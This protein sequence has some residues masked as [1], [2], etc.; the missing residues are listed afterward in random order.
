MPHCVDRTHTSPDDSSWKLA[1]YVIPM[2]PAESKSVCTRNR[3]STESWMEWLP[4]RNFRIIWPWIDL[5]VEWFELVLS[6]TH[7]CNP[8]FS[9]KKWNQRQ[10][11]KVRIGEVN[12]ETCK[13]ISSWG[14][15]G[16]TLKQRM[17]NK[18]Y[19]NLHELVL[20]FH[21]LDYDWSNANLG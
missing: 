18:F 10:N 5:D 8:K 14:K 20:A 11:S 15:V 1:I 21:N 12:L 13:K 6:N 3:L 17:A 19:C 7:F 2:Q 9:N 4:C 16:F